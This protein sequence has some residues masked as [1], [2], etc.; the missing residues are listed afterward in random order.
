MTR[1]NFLNAQEYVPK[2]TDIFLVDANIL[3]SFFTPFGDHDKNI[4]EQYERFILRAHYNSKLVVTS[5]TLSELIYR[6]LKN[7]YEIYNRTNNTHISYRDYRKLQEFG[8]ELKRLETVIERQVLRIM[9]RI[10]DEFT[11]IDVMNCF[12]APADTFDFS[13]R[14]YIEL[15]KK[16]NMKILTNDLDFS[17][18]DDV[19]IV[20]TNPRFFDTES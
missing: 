15:A 18:V 17:A 4:G 16:N 2:E 5:M 3:L 6:N 8:E 1:D 9:E 20:T 10:D 14:Y 12:S 11:K 7:K 13:D 19:F